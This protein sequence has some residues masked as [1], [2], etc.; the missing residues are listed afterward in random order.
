MDDIAPL[1]REAIAKRAIPEFLV[2][3]SADLNILLAYDDRPVVIVQDA[4]SRDSSHSLLHIIENS[5]RRGREV[6]FSALH[7]DT[8]AAVAFIQGE[9]GYHGSCDWC[10]GTLLQDSFAVAHARGLRVALGHTHPRGF[11]A[12]CSDVPFSRDYLL[13]HDDPLLRELL[14]TGLHQRFGGDYCEM[15]LRHKRTAVSDLFWIASPRENQLGVFEIHDAG[16]VVYRP[17]KIV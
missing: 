12:I 5:R 7:D 4:W 14:V 8:D 2:R 17:W 15:L 10:A 16:R 9:V 13:H 3:W 6:A 11:G 1:V